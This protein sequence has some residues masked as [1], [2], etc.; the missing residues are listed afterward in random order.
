MNFNEGY[1]TT[2]PIESECL[3]AEKETDIAKNKKTKKRWKLNLGC[4]NNYQTGF[5]NC[6][7]T[8]FCRHMDTHKEEEYELE[9]LLDLEYPL[10]FKDHSISNV[11]LDRVLAHT[12]N[13]KQLWRELR[14][15]IK[16][17]TK[18]TNYPINYIFCDCYKGKDS[19]VEEQFEYTA[20]HDRSSEK[21]WTY[22]KDDASKVHVLKTWNNTAL[23]IQCEKQWSLKKKYDALQAITD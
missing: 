6:D 5:V 23:L 10:P 12:I 15:I 2:Y 22:D 4:L 13:R 9:I 17:S 11:M 18:Y 14:R 16:Y 19:W 1:N 8:K 3:L 7:D 21:E 20:A